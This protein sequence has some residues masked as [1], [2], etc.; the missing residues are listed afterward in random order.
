M[1]RPD[2]P[3]PTLL[4][5]LY[6]GYVPRSP[7]SLRTIRSYN[8]ALAFTSCE[9]K[10]GNR[11]GN[12]PWYFPVSM[13]GQSVHRMGSTRMHD[14]DGA[15]YGQIF[16]YDGEEAPSIR[17]ANNQNQLDE[18]LLTELGAM[19]CECNP[20]YQIYKNIHE[21]TQAQHPDMCVGITPQFN[22]FLD[23]T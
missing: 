8:A 14:R 13:Q 5:N 19:L 9:L 18:G 11:L 12:N 10:A 22:L 2:R 1:P 7:S 4:R 3:F 20:Y 23:R 16:F 15:H 6:L 17:N 21:I